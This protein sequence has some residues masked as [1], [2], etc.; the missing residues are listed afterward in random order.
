MDIRKAV[1]HLEAGDW[2]AAHRIVQDD[3][4]PLAAWAHGI[5]HILEGDMDNAGYWYRRAGRPLPDAA[6][7]D[8]EIAALKAEVARRP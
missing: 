4:G 3:D 6:A 8:G 5:V 7:V 1:A 2:E